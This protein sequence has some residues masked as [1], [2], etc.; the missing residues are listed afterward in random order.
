MVLQVQF[1]IDE[2]DVSFFLGRRHFLSQFYSVFPSQ[3]VVRKW[4]STV[5]II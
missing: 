1:V 3:N 5:G 4:T 2:L